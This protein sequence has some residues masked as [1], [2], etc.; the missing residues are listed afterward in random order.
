MDYWYFSYSWNLLVGAAE[1]LVS[2][3]L[4]FASVISLHLLYLF[5]PGKLSLTNG[6][7]I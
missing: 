4:T 5:K 2:I 6:A 1:S 7:Q 3:Q